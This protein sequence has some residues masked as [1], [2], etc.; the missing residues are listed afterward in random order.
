[1]SV[2]PPAAGD[3]GPRQ[4]QIQMEATT[5]GHG[6][7]Y[8]AGGDQFINETVVPEAAVRPVVEVAAASR[9]VNLPR[10]TRT[11]AGRGEELA[12]LE[13]ALRGGGEVVVAAVHGLGGVGK[14]TLAAHYALAQAVR[15]DGEGLNPVWWITADSAQAIESGLAGLAVALQP[16]LATVLSL[17]AL[18]G[19]ATAWREVAPVQ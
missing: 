17:E 12:R 15:P 1:M 5:F 16:E 7:A 9:L 13:A 18:A 10:H 6:R 2:P 3:P 19:R 14:S 11:F 4:P 8:Q